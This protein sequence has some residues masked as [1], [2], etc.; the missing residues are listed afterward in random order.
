MKNRPI[1]YLLAVL[2]V[3][4]GVWFLERPDRGRKDDVRLVQ[5]FPKLDPLQIQKLEIS[6]LMDGV[7][8]EKKEGVWTATPSP[9]AL[10]SQMDAKN[11]APAPG[12]TPVEADPWKVGAA[13][14]TLS[15]L[16]S[17][18]L[19][20][21]DAGAQSRLQVNEIGIHLKA[22]DAAGQAV[23]DI[24]IGRTGPD[25]VT[26]AVRS[27]GASEV[28]LVKGYLG[29]RFPATASLW[30][31]KDEANS[32]NEKVDPHKSHPARND[33]PVSGRQ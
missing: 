27:N 26:T 33:N 1:I 24:Y 13:L 14:K 32:G 7:T 2:A 28:Y 6:H 10:S 8:L 30:K 15:T 31:T 17:R 12:G 4:A 11:N 5:F 21:R 9:T 20:S 22:Y 3:G 25:L 23:A 18:S 19:L 29:P 16:E